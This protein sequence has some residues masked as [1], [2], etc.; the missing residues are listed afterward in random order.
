MAQVYSVAEPAPG[1]W[2]AVV[3]Q[4]LDLPEFE[5]TWS[6][7][8]A[9]SCGP[10][11]KSDI[12]TLFRP[13][14]GHFGVQLTDETGALDAAVTMRVRRADGVEWQANLWDDGLHGDGTA[15][16]GAYAA[17]LALPVSAEG[18]V[19]SIEARGLNRQKRP[20]LRSL[21]TSFVV[22]AAGGASL[23]AGVAENAD[24]DPTSQRIV[25]LKMGINL[26]VTSRGRYTLTG[27]LRN[28]A[29]E[30]IA[31]DCAR[32]I[33]LNAGAQTLTLTFPAGA[34]RRHGIDGPLKL[35]NLCFGGMEPH[36]RSSS[37]RRPGCCLRHP[38]L[39]EPG[40]C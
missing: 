30:E 40:L 14:E 7:M 4:S 27:V 36:W 24:R 9:E 1:V 35:A 22:E 3:E 25:S 19:A 33:P 2:R 21:A 13:G 15:G 8:S 18:Y 37:N 17:D 5:G 29:G 31:Y 38:A 28:E 23:A 11:L 39:P 20:F 16:D 10:Y 26:Q 34:I 32:E 6:V 12:P